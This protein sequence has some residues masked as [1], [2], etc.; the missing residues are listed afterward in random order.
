[1]I[2]IL[3]AFGSVKKAETAREVSCIKVS[4]HTW[5]Q[6]VMWLKTCEIKVSAV[7]DAFGAKMASDHDE[8][9]EG[10]NFTMNKNISFLP[11]HVAE[12]FPNLLVFDAGFCTIRNISKKNFKDLRK[13]KFL[14]LN[15]NAIVKI[16]I[17]TFEDLIDLES[18]DM[19]MQKHFIFYDF[20]CCSFQVLTK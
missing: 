8:S 13:L 19:G 15:N 16:A 6:P 18:L 20:Q 11:E 7:I 3:S 12:K 1:L 2:L 5:G 17:D 10:L 14:I 9:M 4:N